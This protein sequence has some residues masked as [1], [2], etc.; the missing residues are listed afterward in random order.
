M[1]KCVTLSFIFSPGW[2]YISELFVYVKELT[3][4]RGLS[5]FSSFIRILIVALLH[6]NTRFQHLEFPLVDGF[7]SPSINV[8]HIWQKLI[9]SQS[10]V[11]FWEKLIHS[12]DH[13]VFNPSL[14]HLKKKKSHLALC[15]FDLVTFKPLFGMLEP[16][17][18]AHRSY[19][20]H[21]LSLRCIPCLSRLSCAVSG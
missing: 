16:F 2:I 17:I 7:G 15:L 14:W 21:S 5:H 1:H 9:L 6:F 13:C 18:S 20:L 10:S 3:G 11:T 8:K 19:C 4:Y 12:K